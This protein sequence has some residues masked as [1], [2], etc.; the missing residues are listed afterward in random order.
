MNQAKNSK[1]P[2]WVKW[3]AQDANG[4]ANPQWQNSLKKSHVNMQIQ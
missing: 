2:V 4:Q 3:L 1:L